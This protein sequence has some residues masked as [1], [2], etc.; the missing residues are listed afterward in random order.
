MLRSKI[1]RKILLAIVLLVIVYTVAIMFIG[2]PKIDSTIKELEEQN[3]KEVL[4][5]VVLLTDNVA[6]NLDDFKEESLLRHKKELSDIIDMVHSMMREVHKRALIHPE[7]KEQLKNE[8]LDRISKLRYAHSNYVFVVDYNATMLSHPY[9]P[10]GSDMSK[11]KD[12]KGRLIVP[13]LIEIA[14]EK[15]EGY[16]Q[17][18]WP[19]N[20]NENKAYEKLTYSRDCPQW[21]MVIG[22]GVY[23]DDIQKEVER[24]KE[25][26]FNELRQIMKKTKI[27]QTG[28]I[29]IF[30]E[31]R[32]IIHPNSNING[33]N[34]RK[35]PNPGKG[36][37]IYDDLVKAAKGSGVLRYK[38]DKPTDK[39]NYIYDKISWIKYVPSMKLYVVSS[40]Y[41]DELEEVSTN[42][43]DK[44][45]YLAVLILFLSLLFSTIYLRKLLR[46]IQELAD[47]AQEI[48]KG[49]YRIR[50]KVNTND[51]VGMLARHFNMMVDRLED[52]IVNLDKKIQE[53]T[54]ELQKLAIT[55][56]LTKLYNRRYF[57]E[58]SM[59]MYRLGKRKHEPL[60]IIMLDIDKFK[61]INDTYGHQVGD[62]V[63][64]ALS[65]CINEVKRKSDIACRY[66][67]E[68]F[69]LLLPN[70]GRDGAY[71]V[72]ER[73]RETVA[74][75]TI[76]LEDGQKVTFTIS[77]G[78]SE[79]DYSH[80]KNI[81]DA[82]RRADDAMYIAKKEG[83]N[84]TCE[85]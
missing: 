76:V 45:I 15:G 6:R 24:R 52:Q 14:R 35:L 48:A 32:M 47:T 63:I 38:W 75:Y 11:V 16:I 34:F 26:L 78:V 42:L 84:R 41:V 27:G 19:K 73:L 60:S 36:T 72:A 85:L 49:N 67:G 20:N 23:I 7:E 68:E 13:R 30:D 57:S 33:K 83:R 74:G 17:Y 81:E 21:K 39:G 51:E 9:I 2:L 59:E 53:K 12:I 5:K 54:A 82:I 58:I 29:Y 28:Y 25:E 31:N 66:G 37:Y 18:W 65:Q 79:V 22:T 71:G 1:L 62:Q 56:A 80:D 46:P 40:A 4:D 10:K 43:H 44:I 3:A 69:I 55:D 8:A 50:A 77:L 64:I 70:T 61:R